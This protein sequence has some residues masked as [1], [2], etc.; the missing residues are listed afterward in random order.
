[1]SDCYQMEIEVDVE[2]S[3]ETKAAYRA[4]GKYRASRRRTDQPGECLYCGRT[5]T[6]YAKQAYCSQAHKQAAYRERQ[7]RAQVEAKQDA[8][9][10]SEIGN[11]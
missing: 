10:G 11:K 2:M 8:T 6:G 4:L 5:F 3:D 1:M 7:K 9:S